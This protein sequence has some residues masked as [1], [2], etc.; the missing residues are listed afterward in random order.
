MDL[1]VTDLKMPGHISGRDLF[2]WIARHLPDLSARVIFTMSD[3]Q[4]E[5]VLALLQQTGCP[6]VQKPFQ[7]EEFLRVVRHVVAQ[8]NP[9][10]ASR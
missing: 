6:H 7:M 4:D 9:P 3:A 2:D 8:N 5:R 10:S 1:V